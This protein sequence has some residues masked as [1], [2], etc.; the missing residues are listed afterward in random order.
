[1]LLL[2]CRVRLRSDAFTRVPTLLKKKP[3]EWPLYFGDG[4]RKEKGFSAVLGTRVHANIGRWRVFNIYTCKTF[5]S[6]GED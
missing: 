2:F 1:M 4:K 5:S 6:S 3:G